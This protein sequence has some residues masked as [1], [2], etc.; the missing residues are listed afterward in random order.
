MLVPTQWF[1]EPHRLDALFV[2]TTRDV[3]GVADRQQWLETLLA[4]ATRLAN[5]TKAAHD[6]AYGK[7]RMHVSNSG[8][9]PT[10]GGCASIIAVV[11]GVGTLLA[12]LL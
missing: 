4:K 10:A 12:V 7:P 11:C 9:S 8:G 5:D 1:M 2:E 3:R 6:E